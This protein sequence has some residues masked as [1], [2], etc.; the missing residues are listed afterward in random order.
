MDASE[1][2]IEIIDNTNEQPAVK[3]RL[4]CGVVER[5]RSDQF[6]QVL[7]T[8]ELGSDWRDCA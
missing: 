4:I 8:D 5:I 7:H 6:H 2:M 1:D 3:H